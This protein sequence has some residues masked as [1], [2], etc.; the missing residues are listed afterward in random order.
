VLWLLNVRFPK[1]PR[2]SATGWLLADRLPAK[3][4]RKRTLE[5]DLR[6]F[7]HDP[8]QP[9]GTAGLGM[10]KFARTGVSEG[11][12]SFG[13]LTGPRDFELAAHP[14]PGNMIDQED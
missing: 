10:C 2:S 9:V 13:V 4:T 6:R 14:W 5:I 11:R 8:K 12:V 1:I 3:G 7:L